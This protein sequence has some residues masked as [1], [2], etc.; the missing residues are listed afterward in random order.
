MYSESTCWT[1]LRFQKVDMPYLL[2]ELALSGGDPGWTDGRWHTPEGYV[3]DPMEALVTL[4]GRMSYPNTWE[5]RIVLLGGRSPAAY[6]SIFKLVLNHIF[7]NFASKLH[8]ITRWAGQVDEFS[9]AIHDHAPAQSC[10]GFIDGTF[11]HCSRPS[12]RQ[13]KN[14]NTICT[15][16]KCT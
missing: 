8:D 15:C 13:V 2:R 3:F 10:I 1:T 6:K 9:D 4:L 11:R 14:V 12:D 7:D 5:Q 16:K